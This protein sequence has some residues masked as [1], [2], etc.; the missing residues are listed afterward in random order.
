M[1]DKEVWKIIKEAPNYSV[2][3]LGNIRM[4]GKTITDSKGVV[5][6]Y[7]SHIVKPSNKNS[8]Y[9][10]VSLTINNNK[11]IHRLIHRLVLSTFKPIDNMESMEVNH[12]D[13]NKHNNNLNNLEWM[14]SK[15]NCNYGNRNVKCKDAISKKVKCIE[16]GVV[17]NSGYEASLNTGVNRATISRS[18]N[19]KNYHPRKYHWEEV[20]E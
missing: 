10:E 6:K 2:S 17:Y 3:N 7:K 14:T 1:N 20:Y 11:T 8:G 19:N 18:I 5:R 15:E 9:L 13:E 16:T 4:N 12:K